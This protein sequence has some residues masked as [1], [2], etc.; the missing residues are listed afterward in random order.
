M[1]F[2]N[3]LWLTILL[4][5]LSTYGL[6]LAA[7]LLVILVFALFGALIYA[8][9]HVVKYLGTLAEKNLS[10]KVSARI[11]DALAKLETNI[12]ELLQVEQQE[13]KKMAKEAMANDGKIDN[14]EL[15]AMAHKIAEIAVVRMTPDIDTFKKYIT[16]GAIADYVE[17]KVTAII[18]NSLNGILEKQFGKK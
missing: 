11:K 7:I 16:G 4:P 6:T 12:I 10:E 8:V 5:L 3:N 2:L 17:Q 13:L 15:K 9:P 1:E 14:D 18:S